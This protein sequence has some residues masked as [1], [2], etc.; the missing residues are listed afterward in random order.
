MTRTGMLTIA[1]GV[2]V[3]ILVAGYFAVQF[4]LPAPL[5]TEDD[6]AQ[7]RADVAAQNEDAF[8][9]PAVQPAVYT[10]R[11]ALR[12]VYFGELHTHSRLSFMRIYLATGFR[13]TS[14]TALLGGLFQAQRVNSCS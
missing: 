7:M 10:S 6:V 3:C 4:Y 12:N 1:G 14:L 2:V 11:N 5:L 8:V 9:R 13:S